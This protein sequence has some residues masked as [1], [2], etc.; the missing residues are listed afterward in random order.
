MLLTWCFG[1][2]LFGFFLLGTLFDSGPEYLLPF[3]GWEVSSQ[4]LSV[5]ISS[6]SLSLFFWDPYSVNVSMYT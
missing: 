3:S 1:V 4:L 6:L 5:Q 2:D